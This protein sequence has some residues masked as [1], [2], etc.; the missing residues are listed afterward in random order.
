MNQMGKMIAQ[1]NTAEIYDYEENKILKLYRNGMPEFMCKQEMEGTRCANENS[2]SSPKVFEMINVDDRIGV[3]YEK[4]QGITFLKVLLKNIFKFKSNAKKLAQYHY[5]IHKKDCTS[6]SIINVKDKLKSDIK[7]VSEL[8]NQEKDTL[9]TYLDSLPNGN[10]LCHFDFH[11]DNV[12]IRDG[13][14]VVIDWMTAC[15]GD[16]AADVARTSLLL[17]YGQVKSES[18]IIKKMIMTFQNKLYRY[19]IQEYLR[20]SNITIHD[21]NKWTVPV[22]AARL[23]EWIPKEEKS[24]LLQN[25]KQFLKDKDCF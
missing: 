22:M 19:Y 5:N 17:Q 16:S 13:N 7:S 25:V 21:V 12:I 8:S 20:L 24:I 14:P 23:R 1:G 15:I 2:I 9:F 11:P 6:N 10:K 18:R 4:I 3:I